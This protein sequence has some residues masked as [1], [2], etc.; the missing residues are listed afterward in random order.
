MVQRILLLFAFSMPLWAKAYNVPFTDTLRWK[1]YLSWEELQQPL[2]PV[3]LEEALQVSPWRGNWF[4]NVSGGVSAF[5]GSPLGCE[6]LFGR[7][8]PSLSVS[9]G[10]WFTSAIGVR[11]A[12]HG[13]Q[14]KDATLKTRDYQHL[15]ADLMW[16][17]FSPLQHHNND[18]R[19]DLVPYVGLGIL[20]NEENGKHPFALSYGVQ[21]RYRLSNHFHLTAELG[22]TATFRDFDGMG[23][24]GKWG[25]RMFTLSV[26]L[27]VTLGKTGWKRVMDASPYIERSK[28]LVDYA[29][30]VQN[31]NM[32][33]KRD[34]QMNACII[35]ELEKI[36]KLEGLLDRYADKLSS[37]RKQSDVRNIISVYPRN[38]YSGLN[39]L[40]ARLRMAKEASNKNRTDTVY[41]HV[42]DSTL[43]S[44]SEDKM[45]G[46]E[47]SG[48]TDFVRL[49]GGEIIGPPIHFFFLLNTDK[50]TD[51]SQLV[52]LD[53]IARI[54]R[55]HG[56]HIRITGAADRAT[57]NDSINNGLS[58]K[59]AAY[60]AGQLQKRGVS[61]DCI[62]ATSSGGIDDYTPIEANRN[63]CVRLLLP[64]AKSTD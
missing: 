46:L 32:R 59:R 26:G 61:M 58:Q 39:S 25:D 36:L 24:S 53:G 6:D 23:A 45:N 33:L 1:H 47:C 57:G 44:L 41:A 34:G 30:L 27:S 28:R 13:L 29:R 9:A 51:E 50:L 4:V 56:L 17:V 2:A 38:N 42:K 64:P 7:M 21:G 63:A 20:H 3:Y 62:N 19:W 60:I 11:V 37:L 12:F 10:K 15:H 18:F 8:K 43:T 55:K 35:A 22:S 5:I 48:L 31:E 40:R 49:A 52:N 54:A 16:N 14:F